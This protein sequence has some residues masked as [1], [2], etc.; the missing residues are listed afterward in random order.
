MSLE[1]QPFGGLHTRRK[2]DVL[3]NYLDAY[4]TVMKKQNFDLYYLDGFAGSGAS[5]AK[6]NPDE[7]LELGLVETELIAKGSPVRALNVEPPFDHYIFIDKK[8]SNIASLR[9]EITGHRN[10][11]RVLFKPGD[12]NK[13]ISEFCSLLQRNRL[14]R[15]V[16]FLDPFGRSVNWETVVSLA[17]TEK[18]D[19]WYLVPVHAM[20]RQVSKHGRF[21]PTSD[22]T[23][24]M[25]GSTAW[26]DIAV[27]KIHTGKDLFG[28]VDDRLE[29]SARATEFSEMFHSQLKCAFG[30]RVSEQYLP[31]GRG[32]LH[33]FSLMFACANPRETAYKK[34]LSI[35]NYILKTA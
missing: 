25:C 17:N 3:E 7:A 27:R 33:E 30:G 2:L 1:A 6:S 22:I 4:V 29:K 19:L 23:D 9:A 10:A 13:A 5:M 18:V 12:A 15:A 16:V 8:E 35:A 26:R 28:A 31:L 11:E 24:R 21:L 34:A 20:S 14:A 32:K